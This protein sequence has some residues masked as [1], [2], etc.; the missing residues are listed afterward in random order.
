MGNVLVPTWTDSEALLPGQADDGL[1]LGPDEEEVPRREVLAIPQIKGK[2]A[3]QGS[4]GKHK[5]G[6]LWGTEE[7]Q[8]PINLSGF[9]TRDEVSIPCG[10]TVSPSGWGGAGAWGTAVLPYLGARRG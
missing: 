8:L 10:G 5:P 2:A 1:S 7:M 6:H 4:C 3:I 9:W